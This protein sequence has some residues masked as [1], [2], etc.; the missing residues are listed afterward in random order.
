MQLASIR[1]QMVRGR[2]LALLAAFTALTFGNCVYNG[3]V[4][5]DDN[6]ILEGNPAF[7][8]RQSL[9]RQLG[10][11]GATS[12]G[13]RTRLQELPRTVFRF[14]LNRNLRIASHALDVRL[15]GMD[16]R[17]HHLMNVAY[18]LAAAF[19]AFALAEALL[20][21]AAGAWVAALVFSLHPL[22]TESV[23]YLAGRRDVLSG[24]L[25]F[26]A[27][28]FWLR[29]R[30]TGSR[31]EGVLAA[32]AF[33]LGMSAKEA[34]AT[35]PLMVLAHEA[36]SRFE[37]RREP[38]TASGLAR[39]AAGIVREHAWIAACVAAGGA[40]LLAWIVSRGL[41]HPLASTQSTPERSLFWYGGSPAA[42]WATVPRLL[43][44]ALWLV[45][46]P[47]SLLADY[48]FN[49][50]PWSASFLDARTLAS[51]VVLVAI[52]AAAWRVLR[53]HPRALFACAWAVI[54]YLPYLP[55]VPTYHNQQVFAEHWLYVSLFG[56]AL[57]AGYA[58]SRLKDRY[59][60]PTMAACVILVA[61][62]AVR[63]AVRNR[64]WRDD[65]SLWMKTVASAPQCVRARNGLGITYFMRNQLTEGAREFQRAIEI[66]GT[67]YPP[68]FNLGHLLLTGDRP[69]EAE[70]ALQRSIELF[71]GNADA[72]ANLGA[73]LLLQGR[74]PSEV[75]A[76]YKQLHARG[77][78]SPLMN[79]N[80]GSLLVLLG[81]YDKAE[82]VYRNVI[83][84]APDFALAR[85]SLGALLVETGRPE[86]AVRELEAALALDPDQL[87]ARVARGVAFGKLRRTGP[88]LEELRRAEA[89][90]LPPPVARILNAVVLRE[91]GEY[92]RSID[93][94]HAGPGLP[95]P[96]A[97]SQLGQTYAAMGHFAEAERA[98]RKA[99]SASPSA[100]DYYLLAVVLEKGRKRVEAA[101][102]LKRGLELSPRHQPSLKLLESLR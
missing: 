26:T 87:S 78:S 12:A 70:A 52:A 9:E 102:A 48:T 95:E 4:G 81:E 44:N 30:Q 32:A 43:T 10:L 66:D 58:V 24:L 91:A 97:S 92:R 85:T 73:A 65:L 28:L 79:H 20:A 71:P 64:D 35:L 84:A 14:A 60:A 31:T 27:F 86:E 74:P 88:A 11:S 67:W 13:L 53:P 40:A 2:M 76:M 63:S 50:F 77:V 96:E 21:D 57:L 16:L 1:D 15:F 33:V 36:L 49:A 29:F 22:Q 62:M 45:V 6:M 41:V 80:S 72:W 75:E 101:S 23:A 3:L 90:G 55:W 34:A 8:N 39:E 25:Y 93:L 19:A 46:W 5:F 47:A 61:G 42:H 94:L 68:Y 54:A 99:L 38:V 51:L 59:P 69:K 100:R 37:T 82:R 7:T 17:W 89:M 18:H 56:P 83:A 98:Y